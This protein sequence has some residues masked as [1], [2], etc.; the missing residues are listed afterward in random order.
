MKKILTIYHLAAVLIF[1]LFLPGCLKDTVSRT[2]TMYIPVYK[3]SA[4]VRANIK[5]DV[6]LAVKNPGKMFVLGNYIYLNEIDKGIHVIDN[7]NPAN[8]VNKYFIAI[9][10]NIDLA[11]TGNTLYADLYTDLVTLD[12]ADPSALQVKKITE[13][14]FPF[15][16]YSGGF[17]AD[18][19]KIITE[20]IKKDT[21][22]TTDINYVQRN[23]RDVMMFDSQAML[24]SAA[25]GSSNKAAI[26]ISGSMARFTLLNNYLYTVTDNAL[27]VFNISQP[28]NPVFSNKINLPF[29]IETIY[30][31]KSNLFIGS[32]TGMFI[33]G[34]A[35]PDKPVQAGSFAHA[36]VCDPV[37]ADDNYAY[38]TLR[39]GNKCTGFTNQLDVVNI[40]NLQ[41][42]KLVKSYPLTNPH[43]LSK[44]GNTL[45]ICDGA[46]GLK[47]FDATDVNSI[48]LLQTIS[49]INAY[50]VIT[51]NGVAIVVAKDGLY[52][53]DYT[54][55]SKV[56]L[57]SKISYK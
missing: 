10:G 6:P 32:Q 7:S 23:R 47:V 31:F 2:Y 1:S 57:L 37:I 43:G 35:N 9:P 27:N 22:V 4:E 21:T 53:Y 49:G 18:N 14:V 13:N 40:Q 48:K 33:Y 11:V 38:V 52:E 12:I 36:R 19:T 28:Q 44:D 17:V 16:R 29:G 54:D 8:P 20:W 56:H 45:F 30:P 41:S 42:P 3:T 5:N 24:L 55:R 51:V 50:D 39:S 46:A 26:G 34:T 25:S 15:R